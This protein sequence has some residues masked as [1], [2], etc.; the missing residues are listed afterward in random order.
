MTIFPAEEDKLVSASAFQ[1]LLGDVCNRT[2]RDRLA[3]LKKGRD[4]YPAGASLEALVRW[5]IAESEDHSPQM[6]AAKLAL[7][8]AQQAGQ[9]LKNGIL[10]GDLIKRED[11]QPSW[12]RVAIAFKTAMLGVPLRAKQQ[13]SKLT[14]GDQAL[15]LKLIKDGLTHAGVGPEPPRIG[16]EADDASEDE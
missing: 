2:V 11:I 3:T 9:E 6:R 16:A 5:L 7:V 15:L 1:E 14:K 8:Q 4:K 12:S 10:S 13:I